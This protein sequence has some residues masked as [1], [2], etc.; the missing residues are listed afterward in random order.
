MPEGDESRR[1][2]DIGLTH[3][4]HFYTRRNLWINSVLI[5]VI[6]NISDNH[7]KNMLMFGFNNVQQRHCRLNAMRLMYPIR[8]ILLVELCTFLPLQG[9]IIFFNN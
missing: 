9:R 8:Q 3:V 4:H 5:F 2:D 1:N 6:S 7:I